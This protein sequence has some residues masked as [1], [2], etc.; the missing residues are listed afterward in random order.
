PTW[1]R[2]EGAYVV[3]DQAVLAYTVGTT[4][5][6]ELPG[7]VRVGDEVGLVRTIRTGAVAQP[8]TMVVAEWRGSGEVVV[9][10]DV[11]EI[12]EAAGDS[13][14]AVGLVDAP[15]GARLQVV[16]DRHA[17]VTLPAGTPAS[18]F[19]VVVWRGPSSGRASFDGMLSGPTEMIEFEEGGEAH[20]PGRTTTAGELAPDTSA[21]VVDE[22]GLP[23][24]N[25]GRRNLRPSDVAFFSDGRAAVSTFDGDVWIVSGLDAGLERLEWARFASGLYEPMSL[26]IVQDEVYVYS[27]SGVV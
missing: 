19:R 11:A 24:A 23:I 13:L 1:A 4:E 9:D 14:T 2:W 7:S 22:I 17:V 20:W 6:R 26:E 10:G 8:L 5:V 3:G 27:R 12:H 21:Y 16:E 18:L 15:A 25:P